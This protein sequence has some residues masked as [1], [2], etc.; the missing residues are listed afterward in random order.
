MTGLYGRTERQ[1]EVG[2]ANVL[3]RP[4]LVKGR[5]LQMRVRDVYFPTSNMEAS[6]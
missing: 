1:Q 2:R 3:A 4:N 5:A 6:N